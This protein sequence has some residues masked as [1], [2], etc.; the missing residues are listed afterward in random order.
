M[1]II[2]AVVAAP[3]VAILMVTA[4]WALDD[5]RA[6]DRVARNVSLAGLDVGG[7]E[8]DELSESVAELARELPSTEVRIE[9]GDDA[10]VSTAGELGITVDAD[11]T[12][13]R[14][15]LIGHGDP[16]PARP[17][18]WFRSLF[19]PR[20]ADVAVVVDAEQ[21]SRELAELEGDRRVAPVE[22]AIEADVEGVEVVPGVPGRA[23]TVNDVVRGIPRSLGDVTEAIVI[24]VEQSPVPPATS[25]EE[26][27]AL[28]AQ[29][30]DITSGTI[31]L[32]AAGRTHEVDGNLFRPAVRL[33]WDD[34]GPRIA[35]RPEPIAEVIEDVV[36][37]VR[38]HRSV[39]G[40]APRWPSPT[41]C[42]QARPPS[43]CPPAR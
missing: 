30:Q 36:T 31:S 14:V 27:A 9:Y 33:E 32:V 11:T 1:K 10:L 16:L 41:P 23:I 5:W 12:T 18:R 34:G 29:A 13:E 20:P 39:A 21:L 4:A 15:M 8:P 6:D 2:L 38:T 25:D 42:S 26:I 19:T 24:P 17:I 3:L 40:T 28:A 7:Q 35:L 43:S 22:P 37:V